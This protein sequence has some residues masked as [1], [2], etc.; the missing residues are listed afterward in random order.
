MGRASLAVVI[1]A[2]LISTNAESLAGLA[3]D[4][5]DHVNLERTRTLAAEGDAKAIAN[6]ATRYWRGDGVN[7]DPSRAVDLYLKAAELGDDRAML[8]LGVLHENGREVPQSH[9]RAF[10]WYQRAVESGNAS[11]MFQLGVMYWAGRGVRQDLVEAYKWFDLGSTHA[12]TASAEENA[13][14]R[15]SVGRVLSVSQLAEARARARIWQAAN[16]SRTKRS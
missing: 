15:E 4:L 6:L 1:L 7:R 8:Q 3:D 13:S 11:A 2:A 9:E 12:D 5:R 16:D 10:A 14:A